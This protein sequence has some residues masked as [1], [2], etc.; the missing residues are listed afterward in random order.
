MREGHPL[1][2]KLFVQSN[3][4]LEP[5]RY[6]IEKCLFGADDKVAAQC[7]KWGLNFQAVSD[8]NGRRV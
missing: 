2:T 7:K 4:E 5:L 1:P 8:L 6:T 3:P